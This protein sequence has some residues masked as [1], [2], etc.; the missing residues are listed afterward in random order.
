MAWID[1]EGKQDVS[2]GFEVDREGDGNWEQLQQ[3][4]AKAGASVPV[5]FHQSEKGLW[6][7]VRTDKSIKGTLHLS[8][9]DQR[10]F[11]NKQEGLFDGLA[12]VGEQKSPGGLLYGLGD[13]RRALGILAGKVTA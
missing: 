10:R 8:Y 7:R 2:F 3:V 4:T 5:N 12:T 6:I 9:T 1:H 11:S 13:N